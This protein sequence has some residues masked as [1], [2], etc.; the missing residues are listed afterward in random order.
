[1]ATNH[2]PVI[3]TKHDVQKNQTKPIMK[4]YEN[5]WFMAFMTMKIN[6]GFSIIIIHPT[7]IGEMLHS[8][9][10]LAIM[11]SNQ[12]GR[13]INGGDPQFSSISNDG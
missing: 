8:F 11:V 12:W 6:H 2:Q 3:R 1:M 5:H 10:G 13:S 9:N 7:M 4:T